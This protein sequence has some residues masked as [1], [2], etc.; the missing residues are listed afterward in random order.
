MCNE[1]S[2]RTLIFFI[3][4][5]KLNHFLRSKK[6]LCTF[7]SLCFFIFFLYFPNKFFSYPNFNNIFVKTSSL[8]IYSVNLLYFSFK[9]N[10]WLISISSFPKVFGSTS[11]ILLLIRSSEVL[12]NFAGSKL[13]NYSSFYTKILWF[14][15]FSYETSWSYAFNLAIFYF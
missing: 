4:L 15:G 14:E 11:S 5:S 8:F 9:W 6:N 3:N 12:K 10:E 1:L 2:I 13:F 7:L